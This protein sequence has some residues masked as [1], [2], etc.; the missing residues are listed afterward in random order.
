MKKRV[1]SAALAVTLAFAMILP[2]AADYSSADA[3]KKP[4]LSKKKLTITAG[5]SKV[6]KVKN[7]KKKVTWKT[8]KASVVKLSAKKKTSVK[9]VAKKKGKANITATYKQGSK[10]VKLTCKVTVKAKQANEITPD[11][12]TPP[13]PVTPTLDPNATPSPTPTHDYQGDP[14][15]L[16]KQDTSGGTIKDAFDGYFV[17]GISTDLGSL[18]YG[19]SAAL[20]KHHFG[21]VTMG[22]A[23]KMECVVDV[24]ATDEYPLGLSVANVENYYATNGEGDVILNYETLEEILSYCK[25]NGL[26]L[27]YHA[28]VW[29]SQVREYFFL[30]DYNWS[31]FELSEYEEKGWDPNNY[32]KFVD[33]ET[34]KKRLNSY[35][36]QIIEYIYSHGYGD[37]VYAYDVIN[38]ATNGD[39]GNTFHYYVNENASTVD[40]LLSTSGSGLKFQTNGGVRTSG[41]K[42]VDSNSAPADVE[43]M[44]NHEG[45]VPANDSY[46][47]SAMG[48]D[49]LYYSFLFAHEAIEKCYEQYKDQ[50]GY[51]Q[52]PSLIYNDYNQRENDHIAL[53]K[54]IN[55]ACNIENGTTGVTYCDG[56]GLQSHSVGEGTQER[57]IKAIAD[58]GFEVQITELDEGLHMDDQSHAVKMKKLYALYKKYSKKGEYGSAQ[59]DD[60]IGV[61]SVTQWGIVPGGNWKTSCVFDLV[62]YEKKEDNPDT[63]EDESKW[64]PLYTILPRPALYAI[65]Q[66]GGVDCGDKVY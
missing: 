24:I 63:E 35:I 27:R 52:K 55:A 1:L 41:G 65:L 18:R 62:D 3:A 36:S 26:K 22:N 21:S 6:L 38:E 20:V 4:A 56:I 44:L 10:S 11:P 64:K 9:L 45:R 66:A 51:T 37:V 43:D 12:V 61:T 49:Y 57:M 30:Q 16:W 33:Y 25:A 60:Y 47:Y 31:D 29:H 40:G 32:H 7:Y 42:R 53:A 39:G 15:C 34:F 46:W 58:Q 59:G 19:E 17:N 23:N 8:S 5:S 14:G 50:F 13:E 2:V 54:F 28:F 48:T